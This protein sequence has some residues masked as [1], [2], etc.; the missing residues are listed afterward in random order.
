MIELPQEK[1]QQLLLAL[2]YVALLQRKQDACGESGTPL[3][4]NRLPKELRPIILSMCTYPPNMIDYRR[5]PIS[6]VVVKSSSDVRPQEDTTEPQVLG[7]TDDGKIKHE[8]L[9]KKYPHVIGNIVL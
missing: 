1:E 6:S 9:S 7:L 2:H 5:I 8:E 4:L 3:N